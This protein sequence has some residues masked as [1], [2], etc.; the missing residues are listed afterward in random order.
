MKMIDMKTFFNEIELSNCRFDDDGWVNVL[1]SFFIIVIY[2]VCMIF[3][4]FCYLRSLYYTNICIL[5]DVC[6][7]RIVMSLLIMY[8]IYKDVD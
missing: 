3:I 6:Y 4:W 1:F 8:D 5:L 2:C 7:I